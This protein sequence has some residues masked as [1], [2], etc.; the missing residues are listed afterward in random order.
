MALDIELQRFVKQQMVDAPSAPVRVVLNA[1]RHEG[2]DASGGYMVTLADGT[3]VEMSAPGLES[4]ESFAGC[5]LRVPRLTEAAIRFVFDVA[6][7]G[8]MA[9]VPEPERMGMLLVPGL[10]GSDLPAA[11]S[12]RVRGVPVASPLE[13]S[14]ILARG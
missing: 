4:C 10:D 7:A 9:I 2:P 12:E 5:A 14:E 13:L 1:T 3:I 6:L 8:G 11:L